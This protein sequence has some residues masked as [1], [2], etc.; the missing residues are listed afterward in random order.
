MT[1][2]ANTSIV[3]TIYNYLTNTSNIFAVDTLTEFRQL[4]LAR[5]A[6]YCLSL[7]KNTTHSFICSKSRRFIQIHWQPMISLVRYAAQHISSPRR[8]KAY[9]SV[10]TRVESF[11]VGGN[12]PAVYI[13]NGI[14]VK[15]NHIFGL[16]NS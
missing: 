6:H 1:F 5:H 10:Q 3:Q 16:Y 13:S 7:L 9:H 15:K 14:P 8:H 11:N 12:L 2:N 4:T